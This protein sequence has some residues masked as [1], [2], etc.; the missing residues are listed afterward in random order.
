MSSTEVGK[1]WITSTTGS[2]IVKPSFWRMEAEPLGGAH[3][4]A[5]K[6]SARKQQDQER[7][8]R[9]VSKTRAPQIV[10]PSLSSAGKQIFTAESDGARSRLSGALNSMFWSFKKAI[11][12]NILASGNSNPATPLQSR[13]AGEQ[14]ITERQWS[15]DMIAF[16][17]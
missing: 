16:G 8:K 12:T 6:Q 3:C 9:E 13:R 17:F 7:R 4:S 11:I 15:I 5:K 10:P 14:I 2:K 1:Q